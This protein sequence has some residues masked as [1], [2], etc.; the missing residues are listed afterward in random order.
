MKSKNHIK[1]VTRY[2]QFYKLFCINEN[3]Y[4]H[5]MLLLLRF[6]SASVLQNDRHL[7]SKKNP[8]KPVKF[9]ET[10]R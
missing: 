5:K 3:Y 1:S 7:N 10:K 2:R 6:S 4:T 9:A 8:C